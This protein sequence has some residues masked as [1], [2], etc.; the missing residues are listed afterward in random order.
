ME[1]RGISLWLVPDEKT[2]VPLRSQVE[3]LARRLGTLPLEPHV[4]LLGGLAQADD[5]VLAGAERLAHDTAAIT[6]P[7]VG[8]GARDEHFRCLFVELGRG[9]ALD[10][11]R[12][13]AELAFG[14]QGSFLPHLSLVYGE[15]DKATKARLV[16]ELLG[17]LPLQLRLATLQAVRTQGAVASWRPLQ[18]W[19]LARD[20]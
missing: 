1:A 17:K 16:S 3:S 5:D 15:L 14:G 19:P 7:V 2:L 13:R 20:D 6:L 18:A 12:Q 11:L 10:A 9:A 4:T 8:L